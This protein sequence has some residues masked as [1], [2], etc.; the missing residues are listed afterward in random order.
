MRAITKALR[1]VRRQMEEAEWDWSPIDG[2]PYAHEGS[3]EYFEQLGLGDIADAIREKIADD[4]YS[5]DPLDYWIAMEE[6]DA[7]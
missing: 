4:A 2:N 7:D 3:A 5:G 1:Q 6:D